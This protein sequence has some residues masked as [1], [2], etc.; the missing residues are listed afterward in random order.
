MQIESNTA[1]TEYQRAARPAKSLV[2]RNVLGEWELVRKVGDGATAEVF[3]AR[4][5]AGA[6]SSVDYALKRLKPGFAND[7]IARQMF[8][9]EVACGSQANHQ[10]LLPILAVDEGG[11]QMFHVTPFIDGV[12]IREVING[13]RPFALPRALWIARQ[14]VEACEALHAAE[15]IHG[16]IKPANIVAQS[17]GH[18]TLIDYGF[19][20]QIG[21]EHHQPPC[22]LRTTLSYTAPERFTSNRSA[23]SASDVYSLGVVL[24]EM[25]TGK[26]PF[27]Q[28]QA[29]SL[30][31]AH[32]LVPAPSIRTHVPG[33]PRDVSKLVTRML[34]KEPSRRPSV[35]G[36]LQSELTRMESEHFATAAAVEL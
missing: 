13:C 7:G 18:A 31:E 22:S 34:A 29:A 27:P 8:A 24:F 20:V 10:N 3:A 15:W 11:S 33:L 2:R 25:L 6:I 5:A 35:C 19:S 28:R 21:D 23:S 16:D 36:E 4:P 14:I 26:L 32:L 1:P 9:N 12:A 17:N 30:V